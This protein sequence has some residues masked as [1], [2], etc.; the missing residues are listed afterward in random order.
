IVI[1]GRCLSGNTFVKPSIESRRRAGFN[2]PLPDGQ[3]RRRL[4]TRPTKCPLFSLPRYSGGGLGRG[5]G[6]VRAI[7][8]R[9]SAA[10]FQNPLPNPP[11]E[12]RGRESG[13]PSRV[14][15]PLAAIVCG[16]CSITAA[17]LGAD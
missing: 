14:L 2:P 7:L 9:H 16:I 4:K 10:F 15:L 17:A 6:R 12:Y 5:F 3:Q 8:Q 11:P 1:T 13:S